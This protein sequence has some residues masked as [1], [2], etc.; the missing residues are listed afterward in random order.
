MTEFDEQVTT[1]AGPACAAA[2]RATTA[3]IEAK[4][5]GIPSNGCYSTCNLF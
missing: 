1:S 3:D 5:S 4:L 2:L